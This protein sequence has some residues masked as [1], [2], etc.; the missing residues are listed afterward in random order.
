V[1]YVLCGLLAVDTWHVS[2]YTSDIRGAGTDANVWFVAYG[3]SH[4]KSKQTLY[5]KSDE[6]A[7]QNKGDN[8]EAGE[9]DKMKVEMEHIGTPYKIRIGHDNSGAFA[10]WHLDRVSSRDTSK[11]Q[12]NNVHYNLMALIP[13][14]LQVM[15]C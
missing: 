11:H 5:H 1:G 14:S 12:L 10:G 3:K 15:K 2:V 9:V 8:F 6:I 7:L 4:S 13:I